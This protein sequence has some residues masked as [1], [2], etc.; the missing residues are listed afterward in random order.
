ME[1][2]LKC[3]KT[4]KNSKISKSIMY[5]QVLSSKKSFLLEWEYWGICLEGKKI[6]L[7]GEKGRG[8]KARNLWFLTKK[9]LLWWKAAKAENLLSENT[10]QTLGQEK[11]GE[12]VKSLLSTNSSIFPVLL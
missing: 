2:P 10:A 6:L 11:T 9:H 1:E 7:I 5:K 12:R 8:E 4:P 3:L